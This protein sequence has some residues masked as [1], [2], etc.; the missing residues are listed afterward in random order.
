MNTIKSGLGT[1]IGVAMVIAFTAFI[2]AMVLSLASEQLPAIRTAGAELRCLLGV[3]EA[4][5]TCV[6]NKMAALEEQRRATK[7]ER[8]RFMD[9][10]A[11]QNLVLTQGKK[12]NDR[13]YLLVGTLYED[14]ATRTGVI[15][16]FCWASLDIAGIDTRFGLAVMYGDGRI[17]ELKPDP[18]DLA[19]LEMS[20]RDVDDARA[21]C[22]FP[23]VK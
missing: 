20:A 11:E 22:P 19:L 4:N 2:L 23:R 8:K 6:I 18:A 12:I 21:A 14:T 7:I 16:S 15:R 3:P 17:T 1:A 5:S 9:V 10:M 13:I